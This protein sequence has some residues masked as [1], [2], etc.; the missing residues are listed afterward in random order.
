MV[1]YAVQEVQGLWSRSPGSPPTPPQAPP[2]SSC[3][4]MG[5]LPLPRTNQLW[6]CPTPPAPMPSPQVPCDTLV[7]PASLCGRGPG[8]PAS[9]HPHPPRWRL[10][11]PRPCSPSLS[12]SGERPSGGRAWVVS[13]RLQ[14]AVL[15]LPCRPTVH[16]PRPRL[17]GASQWPLSVGGPCLAR[18]PRHGLHSHTHDTPSLGGV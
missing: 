4:T 6:V 10:R 5:T 14:G 2:P 8:R 3:H 13:W 18:H 12:R 17:R 15:S 9:P 16:P 7:T 11:G 1:P